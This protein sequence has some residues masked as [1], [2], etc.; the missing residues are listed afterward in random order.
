MILSKNK[1]LN[2]MTAQEFIFDTP[3]YK[4]IIINT[5]NCF[6]DELFRFGACFDGYNP[7]KKA[8]TTYK[9][10]KGLC[11]PHKRT[12]YSSILDESGLLELYLE[13]G[14]YRDLLTI[15]VYWDTS[16]RSIMKIGQFPSVAD[17]HIGQIKQYSG[18]L[19]KEKL[20]EFT[21]AIGLA[22]N[23]V[24]I[25]S[26]VYLRRIFEGLV[27]EAAEKEIEGGNID[28]DSFDKA[29]M[30]DKIKMVENHLPKF[31]V[32]NRN[33]YGILS[34]GI[35]ELKEE[36]C[37]GY[38]NI[39]RESIEL[40]LEQKLKEKEMENRIVNAQKAINSINTKIKN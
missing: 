30:D 38:F 20:K 9:I 8:E 16:E 29:R 17:I 40:I 4:K 5:E 24:G 13:C 10:V 36:E 32:D 39:M 15:F 25:G 26:F 2:N 23:G 34:A 1:Q 37:L 21:R 7:Q 33:I 11:N 14:R 19:S 18:V 12:I 22:A 6:I 31:L 35:H 27:T 28:H 3:L